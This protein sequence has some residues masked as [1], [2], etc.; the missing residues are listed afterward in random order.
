VQE[1]IFHE[2]ARQAL[3]RYASRRIVASTL[4]SVC[5]QLLVSMATCKTAGTQ[6]TRRRV[7]HDFIPPPRRRI[8]CCS[9][10]ALPENTPQLAAD[11]DAITLR[12]VISTR[13]MIELWKAAWSSPPAW[14]GRSLAPP[15]ITT[16]GPWPAPTPFDLRP[17][18]PSAGVR[19]REPSPK[20]SSTSAATA[21]TPNKEA[22][23]VAPG[24]SAA[25]AAAAGCAVQGPYRTALL[26]APSPPQSPHASPPVRAEP[27]AAVFRRLPADRPAA[28]AASSDATSTALHT[29]P[30]SMAAA[31]ARELA[32]G[33]ATV[34]SSNKKRSR[35]TCPPLAP[36]GRH[37]SPSPGSR[38][39]QCSGTDAAAAA[40][41]AC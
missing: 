11:I 4:E 3:A 30:P 19:A 32:R 22:L 5:N 33:A 7:G 24:V 18:A 21:A 39:G 15:V 40:A 6:H 37:S 34:R 10:A 12:V 27:S 13:L 14:G 31:A 28:T 1:V 2:A 26:W 16:G 23:I 17:P 29:P 38:Q 41:P 35:P 25:A 8:R 36:P 9:S 20:L